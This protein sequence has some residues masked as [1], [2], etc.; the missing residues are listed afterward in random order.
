MDFNLV[1]IIIHLINIIVLFLILRH[2]LYKP[3]LAF[4]RKREQAIQ[5]AKTMKHE[6][7]KELAAK[8]EYADVLLTKAKEDADDI[9]EKAL[10]DAKTLEREQA[11]A[12]R[13]NRLQ[14]EDKAIS[15]LNA[16]LAK[17]QSQMDEEVTREAL[18]LASQIL[19]REVK[20]DDNK[21]VILAFFEKAQ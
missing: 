1:D 6:I 18:R 3:V 9:I 11:E 5:D 16:K 21:D 4:I 13:I 20:A 8:Q 17:R 7:E 2:L 10:L 14:E 15:E 12:S 19:K